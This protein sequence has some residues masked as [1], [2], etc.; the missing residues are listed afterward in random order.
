MTSTLPSNRVWEEAESLI[1]RLDRMARTSDSFAAICQRVV[2]EVAQWARASRVGIWTR[3]QATCECLASV[4]HSEFGTAAARE[5]ES[6]DRDF[7]AKSFWKLPSISVEDRSAAGNFVHAATQAVA[8]EWIVQLVVEWLDDDESKLLD[9]DRREMISEVSLAIIEVCA[10]AFMREQ[11]DAHQHQSRTQ[12]ER[13][14]SIV[15][16]YQGRSLPEAFHQV[17]KSVAAHR[18]SDRVS[19][20]LISQRRC[21]LIAT[22]AS[23]I[24][25]RRARLALNQ[26]ALAEATQE[27]HSPLTL[28][29]GQPTSNASW[30]T[31]LDRYL[32]EAGCRHLEIDCVPS[33]SDPRINLAVIITEWF[34]SSRIACD[35]TF[36]EHAHQAIQQS[37]ANQTLSWPVVFRQVTRQLQSKAVRLALALISIGALL[38]TLMPV[39]FTLP[40]EGQMLPANYRRIFAPTDAVVSSILVTNGQMVEKGSDLFVL[41]SSSLDLREE[42]LRGELLTARTRLASLSAARSSDSTDESSSLSQSLSISAT[43]QALKTE[44]AGLEK[45]LTLVERQKQSLKI[46][47]PLAGIVDRWDLEQSLDN[48]PVTQGQHLIDVYASHGDWNVE[49]DL[50]DQ[51]ASYLSTNTPSQKVYFRLQSQPDR[52]FHA[53]ISEVAKSSQLNTHG[54]AI[55]RVKCVVERDEMESQAIG[56]TVWADIECGKRALGFVWFRGLFEWFGRQAWY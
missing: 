27:T 38:L 39:R 3:G 16:L 11:L 20:L 45:Q 14:E 56:A 28:S 41:R 37:V 52:E 17:A 35:A 19:I 13:I 5:F 48:R 54:E 25:D 55:V 46:Q 29:L 2:E 1:I 12:A 22:S 53:V 18:K 40:V 15:S 4:G 51:Y 32:I 31:T 42:Q 7:V 6:I 26:K 44:I 9:A 50:P 30:Q 8:S 33:T 24:V 49:L 23:Q 43:E 36:R 34:D 21:E 10:T 47:S